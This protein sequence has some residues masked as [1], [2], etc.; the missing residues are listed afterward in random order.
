MAFRIANRIAECLESSRRCH[1][2]RVI[3]ARVSYWF[4]PWA[5][6]TRRLLSPLNRSAALEA[7][8]ESCAKSK[9][10][11]QDQDWFSGP[12]QLIVR[13]P[14]RRYPSEPFNQL[15]SGG[16]GP[17]HQ[18]LQPT[19]TGGHRNAA[20]CSRHWIDGSRHHPERLVDARSEPDTWASGSGPGNSRC[21][22]SVGP[23]RNS[24]AVG[25]HCQGHTRQPYV[26]VGGRDVRLVR[27]SDFGY[28]PPPT[29][30]LPGIQRLIGRAGTV[31]WF[32]LRKLRP[33]S[34][35]RNY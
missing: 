30:R 8:L 35:V 20:C 5:G 26:C 9:L 19:F 3:L 11:R 32:A 24:E 28:G 16:L 15:S 17:D 18:V 4:N 1:A 23:W 7:L 10:L 34:A 21:G 2:L 31:G 27:L 12:N 14:L 6:E 29:V 22:K 13:S 33:R 25:Q